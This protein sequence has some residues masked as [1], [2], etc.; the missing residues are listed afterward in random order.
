MKNTKR[1]EGTVPVKHTCKRVIVT[2]A[3]AVGAIL[4]A[5]LIYLLYVV[6]S[7]HRVEDAL[8]LSVSGGTSEAVP[9][10]EPL[11]ALTYNIG[12]G[13]YSAD[14][15][16]FMDGGEHSRAFSREAVLSNTTGALDAVLGESPSFVMLQ[17]VDVDGTRSYHVDQ[18][19][20][21]VNRFSGFSSVYAENYDS[22]YLF[23]P[24]LEPIGANRSGLLT[25]SA[26]GI[27]SAVR[28]SLPIEEGLYR[29]LD[30]DRAYSVSRIPT[31]N[32]K[33][34][35]LYNVH[36]SAYTS[37]GT[38]ADEQMKLLAADMAAEYQKGNYVIAAGDFNKDLLGDSSQYFPREEGDYTWAKPFDV[39]LLPDGFTLCTGSNAPTCRNADAPYRADGTDFVLSVDGFLVSDNV[40]VLSCQTVD[41]AFAYSDHNP[42]RLA[43][44]LTSDAP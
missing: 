4:L 35:M 37:D 19:Q 28:R 33:Y 6:C 44:L 13:A 8:A 18:T 41:I 20:I 2:L 17:E 15:S 38:I 16:F 7:Y 30:L 22:P 34:L 29:F 26:Y 14:Y 3:C 23:Y 10:G 27:E 43:F 31:D 9:V 24:F 25:F 36:L 11:N 1:T 42:V 21:A 39:T 5:V 12:F 40:E 32:G